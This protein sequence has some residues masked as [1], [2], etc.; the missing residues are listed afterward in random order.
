[1]LLEKRYP[2][3]AALVLEKVPEDVNRSIQRHKGGTYRSP[4]HNTMSVKELRKLRPKPSR[5]GP[6]FEIFDE[7]RSPAQSPS[8]PRLSLNHQKYAK[9]PNISKSSS[10]YRPKQSRKTIGGAGAAATVRGITRK[11]SRLSIGELMDKESKRR[12]SLGKDD[13]EGPLSARNKAAGSAS[14]KAALLARSKRLNV[15]CSI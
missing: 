3:A 2:K 8:K 10:P 11:R 7:P 6:L 14:A 13:T 15:L 1:M 9:S 4:A 5:K 12:E